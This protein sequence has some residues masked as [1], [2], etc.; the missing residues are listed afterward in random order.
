VL[1]S[2]LHIHTDMIGPL[3]YIG[4]K[5]RL[6]RRLIALFPE[7]TTYVEPFCGGGQVFFA[8]PPSRV[9]VLNDLNGEVVNFL[10]VCQH[11]PDE[12]VRSLRFAYA[13][14]R[15]YQLFQR[16]DPDVLTDIQRAARFL[17]LQKNSFGG[18]VV[19]QHYHYCVAKPPNYNPTRTAAIIAATHARLARVQLESWPYERI[20]ERFDRPSTLFYLDPPYVGV[21]LYRFNLSEPDFRLL[22]TRLAKLRGKFVLSINDHPVAR[23]AFGA[24]PMLTV[25]VAYTSTRHPA[26]V[27]ELVFANFTLPP[28]AQLRHR[29]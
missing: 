19:A 14:R 26:H 29:A 7:H 23:D 4:G 20:L 1:A 9:E 6:A 27:R 10:R 18:K 28:A 3:A 17:Y 22:A 25:E 8:K 24:F 11:H 12:L 5:R 21:S 2:F 16:Q 15:I 13:S